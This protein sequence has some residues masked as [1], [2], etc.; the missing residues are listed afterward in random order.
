MVFAELLLR[1]AMLKAK[2]NSDKLNASD[3]KTAPLD[4]I[5]LEILAKS[6]DQSATVINN[7]TKPLTSA[8]TAQ[9]VNSQVTVVPLKMVFAEL[10]LRT[11]MLKDKSN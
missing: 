3:A 7:T 8:S 2:Y 5:L 10:L 4:K 1:T 6:Q 11:A 9:Q